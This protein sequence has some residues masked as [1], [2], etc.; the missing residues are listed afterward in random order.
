MKLS[1]II[2]VYNKERF[3]SRSLGSV[4]ASDNVEVIVVDDGSTDTSGA[5]CERYEN[6]T[7]IRK[8]HNGVSSSRNVGLNEAKGDY[9]TFL[10]ADDEFTKDGIDKMLHYIDKGFGNDVVQFNHLRAYGDQR[11]ADRFFEPE[12]FRNI[13][14]LPKKWCLVWNKIYKRSFLCDYGIYF[15][16]KVRFEEDRLFNL[17]CL[18]YTD[19]IHTCVLETVIKHN[20]DKFSICHTKTRSDVIAISEELTKMLSIGQKPELERVIRR[21]LAEQWD[22]RHAKKLFGGEL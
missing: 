17:E 7:I 22:S 18:K 6:F 3:L 13:N 11:P 4:I 20:D 1:V 8:P 12:G 5:I 15:N 14:N 21:N 19:G 9:I 2:P 10:D 16:P